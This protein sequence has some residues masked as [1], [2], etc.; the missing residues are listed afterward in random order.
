MSTHSPAIRSGSALSA[1]TDETGSTR[2]NGG[3]LWLAAAALPI[4]ALLVLG[5]LI[6]RL[7]LFQRSTL[8]TPHLTAS[9]L[10]LFLAYAGALVISWLTTRRAVDQLK[11]AWPRGACL[12]DIAK[13]IVLL[14]IACFSYSVALIPL[15]GLLGA[16]ARTTF[17]WTFIV[18]ISGC[19]AWLVVELFRGSDALVALFSGALGSNGELVC[20]NCESG[21]ATGATFCAGC[22]ARVAH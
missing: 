8:F 1:Q 2:A 14:T 17:D 16:T 13:A 15:K 3:W 19:A 4:V 22:G 21:I 6:A 18:A 12:G 10:I 7:A 5:S 20:G 9:Q 11:Q